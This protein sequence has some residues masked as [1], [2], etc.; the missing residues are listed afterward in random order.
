[1][2]QLNASYTEVIPAPGHHVQPSLVIKFIIHK[3]QQKVSIKY[4]KSCLFHWNTI[5]TQRGGN[6]L[7]N[8]PAIAQT[9]SQLLPKTKQ[10][11]AKAKAPVT[12]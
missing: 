4:I 11:K 12:I 8:E 10:P 7:F 9:I 6:D 3:L 5:I 2:V 1:M